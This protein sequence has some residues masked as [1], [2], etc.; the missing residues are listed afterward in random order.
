MNSPAVAHLPRGS[1]AMSMQ[2]RLGLRDAARRGN[3]HP[4]IG[5]SLLLF[6][7]T[8]S[9]SCGSKLSIWTP[10][11]NQSRPELD[12]AVAEPVESSLSCL[13][14]GDSRSSLGVE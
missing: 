13:L 9:C 11:H 3:S 4:W 12:S 1:S 10:R 14:A 2:R 8:G 7:I 6:F 5:S